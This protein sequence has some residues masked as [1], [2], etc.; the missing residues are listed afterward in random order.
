[1]NRTGNY[2]KEKIPHLL[3]NLEEWPIKILSNRRQSF[4]DKVV[5]ET[6]EVFLSPRTDLLDELQQASKLETRRIKNEKWSVDPPNERAF[7]VSIEKTLREVVKL[8]EHNEQRKKLTEEALSRIVKVYTEEIAGKFKPSVFQSAR[9]FCAVLFS[10]LCNRFRKGRF[11]F[12]GGSKTL[13]EKI[14]VIGP[15]DRVRKLFKV[16][17]L[18]FVPTHSSNLDSLLLGYALDAYVGI[19]SLHYGAGLNLYNSEIAGYFMNRMGAYRVD[20]RKKNKIYLETLKTVSRTAIRLGVHSLFFPGGTRSRSGEIEQNLKLGLLGTTVQAQRMLFQENSDKR[21]FIVPL[22]IGYSNVLEDK[23]LYINFLHRQ[24]LLGLVR[25]KLKT[26]NTVVKSLRFFRQLFS[27]DMVTYLSIA[28]PMDVFGNHVD[29]NGNSLDKQNNPISKREYFLKNSKLSEDVQRE[30]QYTRHLSTLVSESFRKYNVVRLSHLCAAALLQGIKQ[31]SKI[32]TTEAVMK[33]TQ[34][35][36]SI[37]TTAYLKKFDELVNKFREY[38]NQGICL[39]ENTISEQP[40]NEILI[41]EGVKQLRTYQMFRVVE[42]DE[43]ETRTDHIGLL[44]YYTNRL[45]C[46]FAFE[47]QQ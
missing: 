29:E 34:S 38:D 18:V 42:M 39:I 17:T 27:H 41:Q 26:R 32:L 30:M 31:E 14:R 2:I 6:V 21:I 3:P 7:W 46:Y 5:K 37:P 28:E 4:I 35:E 40:S 11:G 15:V 13:H 19:P 20:R 47:R 43:D 16:G 9:K 25:K 33:L 45:E 36:W 24:G 23:S 44:L 10:V 1:M 12:W 8:P 22:V